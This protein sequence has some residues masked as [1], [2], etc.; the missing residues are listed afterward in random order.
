MNA[1]KILCA[2][3][4]L[5]ALV[6]LPLRAQ[7]ATGQSS[8]FSPASADAADAVG[9]G[10]SKDYALGPG[11]VIE[12]RVFGEPQFDGSYDVDS[13]GKVT[14]PFIEQPL[15]VRCRHI[16]EVRKEVVTHAA[17]LRVAPARP[18]ARTTLEQRR[19]DRTVQRDD[20]DHAYGD[21][22]LP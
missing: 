14:I 2:L 22:R 8:S 3:T 10:G 18:P 1:V 15:E 12:L 9:P 19:R 7:Q 21:G 5:T 16:A 11:D 20:P 17:P 13:E 4:L 6:A